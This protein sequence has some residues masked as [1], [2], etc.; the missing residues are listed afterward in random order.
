MLTGRLGAKK[1][2]AGKG[3]PASQLRERGDELD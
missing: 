3:G 2:L 1:R